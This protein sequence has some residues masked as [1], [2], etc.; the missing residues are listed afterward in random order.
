[1][2]ETIQAFVRIKPYKNG[3]LRKIDWENTYLISD[4]RIIKNK[5]NRFLKEAVRIA[6]NIPDWTVIL[7]HE[8]IMTQGISIIFSQELKEKYTH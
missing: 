2:D 5:Q 8:K 1:M 6:K 4:N 3:K 7:R